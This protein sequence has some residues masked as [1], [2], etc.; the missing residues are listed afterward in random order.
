MTDSH[1][2]VAPGMPSAGSNLNGSTPRHRGGAEDV[3]YPPRNAQLLVRSMSRA[4]F[5]A[6]RKKYFQSNLLFAASNEHAA[7]V[8]HLSRPTFSPSFVSGQV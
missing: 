5:L 2:R 7:G 4:R 3:A 6:R 1:V 8:R